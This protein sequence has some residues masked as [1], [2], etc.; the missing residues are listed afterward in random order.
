MADFIDVVKGLKENKETTDAGFSRLEKAI[1]GTDSKSQIEEK[2]KQDANTT[3]KEQ[4]YFANIGNEL[5]L[6]NKNLV[7]GFKSLVT[8]SG[9]LGGIMALIAAPIFFIKGFLTGLL[10]SFKALNKVFGG[11]KGIRAVRLARVFFKRTLPNFFSGKNGLFTNITNLMKQSRIFR[12]LRVFFK[13]TMP[14]FFKGIFGKDLLKTIKSGFKFLMQP[15]KMIGDIIKMFTSGSG[16]IGGALKTFKSTFTAI[17]KFASTI[18]RVLGRLFLPLTFIMTAFDTIMGAIDGFKGT[19]GN[20]VQKILGGLGGAIKGFMKLVTVPLDLVKDLISW[21]AGKFGFTEFEKLLDGFSFTESFGKAVDWLYVDL[22]KFFIDL[23]SWQGIKDTL[24]AGINFI[25][26]I[27]KSL[28]RVVHK[29]INWVKGI[30][31]FGDDSDFAAAGESSKFAK[32][33][34]EFLTFDFITNPIMGI[35][36][37]IKSIFDFDFMGFIKKLPGVGAILDFIGGDESNTVQDDGMKEQQERTK[38]MKELKK[39]LKEGS[40]DGVFT[41]SEDETA[42]L[43]KLKE[44]EKAYFAKVRA[45][46]ADKGKLKTANLVGRKPTD[47]SDFKDVDPSKMTAE[48]LRAAMTDYEDE[49]QK[50]SGGSRIQFDRRN[51]KLRRS[52]SKRSRE[53]MVQA[54]EENNMGQKMTQA[55]IDRIGN[56]TSGNSTTIVNNTNNSPVNNN[57]SNTTFSPL[58]QVDPVTANAINSGP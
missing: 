58:T 56:G 4:G 13:R 43:K 39:G 24:S 49:R 50:R 51:Q 22:P 11:G 6:V 37:F 26:D 9:A 33:L 48:Q 5:D 23:F 53:F 3:K 2:A 25:D 20:I 29:A 18:G 55:Q 31:G 21:I 17:T 38:R 54:E 19:D 15:F 32:G 10:D 27:G 45:G 35:V 36:N 16:G 52:L 41:D 46:S 28:M 57:S 8:P 47:G 40:Y 14:N 1:G 42:E 30:F 7:D 12:Q 44:E 34:K